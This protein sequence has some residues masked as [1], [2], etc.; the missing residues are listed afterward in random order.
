MA[1][2]KKKKISDL[3]QIQND[4]TTGRP[5][6]NE[7]SLMEVAEPELQGTNYESKS[8]TIEQI[9]NFIFEKAFPV[10][11]IYMSTSNTNPKY[12]FGGEWQA[13]AVGKTIFGVDTSKSDD[14]NFKPGATG[15]SK[16]VTLTAENL[17]Q[18]THAVE[19]AN[20]MDTGAIEFAIRNPY[21]P[22]DKVTPSTPNPVSPSVYVPQG[23]G[24]V[25]GP[26]T[27]INHTWAAGSEVKGQDSDDKKKAD[28]VSVSMPKISTTAKLSNV[29]N[30]KPISL[31]PP[32]VTCYIWKR[33]K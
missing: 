7:A 13:F 4:Q 30:G 6:I 16:T 12:L 11:S 15:G 31:L 25:T 18:H 17:P 10:G 5:I 33:T 20:K 21:Q 26:T 2:I 3:D 19:L 24:F 23:K 32:Y 8:V 27:A 1:E 28:V 14:N 9:R 29:G 22:P